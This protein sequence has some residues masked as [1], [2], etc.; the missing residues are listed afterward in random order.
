MID[1]VLIGG[2][3]VGIWD[4]GDVYLAADAVGEVATAI[5]ECR[6]HSRGDGVLLWDARLGIPNQATLERLL[7]GPGDAWHAGLR[8]GLAG[9]PAVM[10]FIHP[11]WMLNRDPDP[12]IEASSWRL[13][14]RACLLRRAV[15][16]QLD[17]PDRTFESLAGASL[18]IGH[19]Y[20]SSG[21]IVRHVPSLVS[22]SARRPREA[23]TL[24]DEFRFAL[25]RY[26][27]PLAIWAGMRAALAHYASAKDVT[28]ALQKTLAAPQA[29]NGATYRHRRESPR[30]LPEARVSVLIPTLGRYSYLRT[31]LGQLSTQTF[32]PWEVVIVDQ[33]P[34]SSRDL[35]LESNFKNLP[36]TVIHLDQAGQCSSRNKGLEYVTGTHV[37]LL[38]DD[39][40]VPS[41]YIADHLY[42]LHR[43]DA[44]GSCGIV[45]EAGA[46]EQIEVGGALR[47]SDVFPAGNTLLRRNAFERAGLFDLA[48][49]HGQRADIDLG[50]RIYLSGALIILDPSISILHH[51]ARRGG[52]REHGARKITFT[53]SRHVLMH[54]HI[55][56]TTEIY[57]G[58]RYFTE[59]Q[60]HEMLWLRAA[61]TLMGKGRWL[62]RL[63]KAGFGL[64]ALPDT[65][66][67]MRARYSDA[68]DM[69]TRFPEI[70]S[71]AGLGASRPEKATTL[72]G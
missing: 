19:R 50:M 71:A 28:S 4:G 44:D 5:D 2:T 31:L 9:C 24:A 37:L 35:T 47:I 6:R 21:V 65:I 52:L 8:L 59:R 61:G 40:E 57:L 20:L 12:N 22:A 41:T 46:A 25:L 55:P 14:L 38:D 11:I 29:R 45:H 33:S 68:E 7:A 58:R 42:N 53:S 10:D 54:R 70:P 64:A 66:H 32:E 48:F 34:K 27:K 17:G 69:L 36:L 56:S 49:D 39:I 43:F 23:L 16:D 67:K 63:A 18:E 1:L 26:G 60:V 3:E 72:T 62:R 51:R 30:R 15:I 13:S